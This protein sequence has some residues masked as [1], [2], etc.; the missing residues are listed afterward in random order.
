MPADSK[1]INKLDYEKLYELA[2]SC[3]KEHTEIA[4]LTDEFDGHKK[5]LSAECRT[6]FF[7]DLGATQCGDNLELTE[8][9]EVD[10]YG[11][12]EFHTDEGQVT[13][14]FSVKSKAF[15]K[16]DKKPATEVLKGIFKEQYGALFEETPMKEVTAEQTVLDNIALEHPTLFAFN[17]KSGVPKERLRDMFRLFPD[18][19]DVTVENIEEFEK[20]F[21]DMVETNT[22]VKTS[23]GFIEKLKKLSKESL[24]DKQ[25]K[26]FLV[27][28]L[29]KTV[30]TKVICGN[31]SKKG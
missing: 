6:I 8:D 4:R 22:G 5:E 18:V 17:V 23:N 13:V 12:H 27:G 7:E 19:F 9:R 28:L 25:I 30:Q 11:N 10:V 16:I 26:R 24:A 15:T 2:T 1:V 14:N 29:D 31:K 21:P 3:K 20:S